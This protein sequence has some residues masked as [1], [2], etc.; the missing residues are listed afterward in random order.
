MQTEKLNNLAEHYR[1]SRCSEAYAEVYRR[2]TESLW[3]THKRMVTR[4]G[5]GDENDAQEIFDDAFDRTMNREITNDFTF[6]LSA[7]LKVRRLDFIRSEKRR[8]ER[9]VSLD[10]AMTDENDALT[11][12]SILTSTYDTEYEA[13]QKRKRTEQLT[14]IDSL[15]RPSRTNS[16]VTLITANFHK[17]DSARALAKALGLHHETVKREL[18]KLAVNYDKSRF[19]NHRDYYAV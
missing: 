4:S 11:L 1:T 17:Y 5:Y 19:G 16:V 18:R 12:D 7:L 8:L 14:L 2:I 15:L 13:L 6:H 3:E 10:V 9:T